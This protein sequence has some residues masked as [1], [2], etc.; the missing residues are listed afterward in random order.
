VNVTEADSL[1]LSSPADLALFT[2]VG[3]IALP[4]SATDLA[5]QTGASGWSIGVQAYATV[6]VTYNYQECTVPVER[7]TWGRVKGIYR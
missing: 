3:T 4:A 7:L 6:K 2:G 5:S 1:C